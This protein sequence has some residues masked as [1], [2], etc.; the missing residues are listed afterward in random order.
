M[1]KGI[2]RILTPQEE[3]KIK[4]EYL[5]TPVKTLA[6][7]IGVSQTKIR[8]FL[9]K[10]KLIIP[11][12]IAAERRAK[13]QFKKGH[14]PLNKGKEWKDFMSAEAME[15]SRRTQ[16]KP[17]RKP[18]NTKYNGCI[19][20]RADTSGRFYKYIRISEG[21]WELY[22]RYLWEQTNGPIPKGSVLIFKDED[23]TNCRLENL[24]L[25]SVEEH[26]LRNSKHNY[27][28]EIIPTMALIAKLEKSIKSKIKNDGKE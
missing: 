6:R 1:P 9:K 13:S 7:E 3:L 16:F 8:G 19:V 10:H 26:M 25:I 20:K 18:H 22:H 14:V 15:A 23:N 27:P 2:T 28:E 24:E 4:K 11:A 5:T 17:G 12:H 21:K